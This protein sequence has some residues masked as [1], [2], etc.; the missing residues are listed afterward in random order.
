[1]LDALAKRLFGSATAR[2]IKKRRSAD[3]V[4]NALEPALEGLDA[5]P[6]RARTDTFTQRTARGEPAD[7][8]LV[9]A[10]APVRQARTPTTKGGNTRV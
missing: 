5:A 3:V 8:Q 7:D 4:I 10:L 6:S 1:M 2:V 9:E